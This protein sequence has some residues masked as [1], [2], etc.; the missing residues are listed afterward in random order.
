MTLHMPQ[1]GRCN[2]QRERER[3]RGLRRCTAKEKKEKIRQSGRIQAEDAPR[4]E[5]RDEGIWTVD[6]ETKNRKTGRGGGG[7][8]GVRAALGSRDLVWYPTPPP[9]LPHTSLAPHHPRRWQHELQEDWRED[10]YE[11]ERKKG[12]ERKRHAARLRRGGKTGVFVH[13]LLPNLMSEPRVG[14]AR[15]GEYFK[16]C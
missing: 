1:D 11:R 3:E 13:S 6:E 10:G 16:A 9:W 12:Y 14:G 15:V 8:G 2:E 7:E 5:E 4:R